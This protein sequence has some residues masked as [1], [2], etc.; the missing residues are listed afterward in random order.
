MRNS[1]ECRVRG[2]SVW[3]GVWRK[4]R[5]NG[6]SGLSVCMKEGELGEVCIKVLGL[7]CNPLVL[8]RKIPAQWG[9]NSMTGT[10]TRSTLLCSFTLSGETG[11][12]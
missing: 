10:H 9:T 2:C 1:P 6:A 8:V 3:R 4:M 11:L 5:M 7:D 12:G